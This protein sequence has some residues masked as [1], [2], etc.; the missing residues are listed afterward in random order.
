MNPIK[1][2]EANDILLKPEAMSD[3]QCAEL[4][5]YKGEGVIISC[6]KPSFKER[7]DIILGRKIWLWVMAERTH[8]PIAISTYSPFYAVSEK[9]K[10]LMGKLY[11]GIIKHVE[12]PK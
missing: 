10:K 9:L 5:V 11:R 12:E 1:F 6:W 7:L 2:K 3:K 4:H 8:P